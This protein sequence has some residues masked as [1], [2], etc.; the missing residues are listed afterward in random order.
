MRFPQ[1]SVLAL[2][3]N[4]GLLHLPALQTLELVQLSV[5]GSLVLITLWSAVLLFQLLLNQNLY[6]LT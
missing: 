6:S 5:S 2:G 4:L 1:G 3:P